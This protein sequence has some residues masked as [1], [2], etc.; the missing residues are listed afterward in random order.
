MYETKTKTESLDFVNLFFGYVSVW[1]FNRFDF[2]GFI[3]SPLIVVKVDNIGASGGG[4]NG[5]STG[6]ASVMQVR[7]RMSVLYQH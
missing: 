6:L 7:L 5:V 2:L 1:F 4:S 3:C